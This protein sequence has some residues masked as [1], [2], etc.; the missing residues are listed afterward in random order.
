MYITDD[1]LLAVK[2]WEIKNGVRCIQSPYEADAGLQHLEDVGLTDGTFSGDGNF[3][4]LSKK[5]WATKVSIGRGNMMLF[6]SAQIREAIS[7]LTHCSTAAH[8]PAT[9]SDVARKD[10]LEFFI[11]TILTHRGNTQRLSTLEFKVK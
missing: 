8:S 7:E 3:F 10:Y 11:E 4:A 2:V 5:L 9:S 1:M 6:D